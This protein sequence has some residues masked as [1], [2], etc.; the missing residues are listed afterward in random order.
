[1]AKA[2]IV[3]GL[4]YGDEGKGAT[5]DFLCR[6]LGIQTVVKL[7]GGHQCAHHV[8]TDAY[9]LRCAQ[10]GSG[11]LAGASTA[12]T[13]EFIFEPIALMQE[14]VKFYEVKTEHSSVRHP[15]PHLPDV[16]VDLDC[17][18]TTPYEKA[19]NRVEL[20]IHQRLM[21]EDKPRNTC[22][23]GIGVTRRNWHR[24]QGLRASDLYGRSHLVTSLLRMRNLCESAAVVNACRLLHTA[25][26]PDYV[27]ERLDPRSPHEIAD[28][29]RAALDIIVRP[30]IAGSITLS[31]DIVIEGS[32]GFGLDAVHGDLRHSTW[33]DVT[34]R[35]AI[36]YAVDKGYEPVVIGVTRTYTTRHGDGPLTTPELV[37]PVGACHAE[38]NAFNHWQGSFRT[39]E[40]DQILLRRAIEVN[41]VDC[42]AVN[43]WDVLRSVGGAIEKD[44]TAFFNRLPVPIAIVGEGPTAMDR[45][46]TSSGVR[47]LSK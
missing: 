5:V 45:E 9:W 1:M 6:E 34:S 46:I 15:I 19:L 47:F 7:S 8:C 24:G 29:M 21:R 18:M 13:G 35:G 26:A 40:I 37:V 30:D 10:Y 32:Q 28:E 2:Y 41:R 14:R 17:P 39:A 11:T 4:G 27:L 44:T 33:S 12:L 16:M 31:G 25:K 38:H 36:E 42:L 20:E 23:V 43:H 3:V 22:G